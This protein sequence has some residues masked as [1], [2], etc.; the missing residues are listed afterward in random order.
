MKM[1]KE[2]HLHNVNNKAFSSEQVNGKILLI[3]EK[4]CR[5]RLINVS[6]LSI[7]SKTT[8]YNGSFLSFLK[9][10]ESSFDNFMC[11]DFHPHFFFCSSRKMKVNHFMTFDI[12]QITMGFVRSF[13]FSCRLLLQ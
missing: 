9:R 3:L 12:I 1:K 2:K 11:K 4:I 5:K 8:L 13:F 10:I 7:S 6:Q